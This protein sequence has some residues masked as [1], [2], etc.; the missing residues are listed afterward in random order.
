MESLHG[1]I[2]QQPEIAG[3][4]KPVRLEYEFRYLERELKK[5]GLNLHQKKVKPPK[6]E[7]SDLDQPGKLMSQT[8][9]DKKEDAADEKGDDGGKEEE[10]RAV[11]TKVEEKKDEDDGLDMVMEM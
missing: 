3:E 2:V 10:T 6:D 1:E 7:A 8:D 5:M 11:E 9:E 4:K